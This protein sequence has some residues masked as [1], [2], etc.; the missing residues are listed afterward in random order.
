MNYKIYAVVISLIFS[1]IYLCAMEKDWYIVHKPKS[2]A[3]FVL[4]VFKN[5]YQ[6]SSENTD[7]ANINPVDLSSEYA[8][9]LK[10]DEEITKETDHNQNERINTLE[11]QYNKQ[12]DRIACLES[13]VQQLE[14]KNNEIQQLTCNIKKQITPVIQQGLATK[15][16]KTALWAYYCIECQFLLGGTFTVDGRAISKLPEEKLKEYEALRYRVGVK[17]FSELSGQWPEVPLLY[18]F[19]KLHGIPVKYTPRMLDTYGYNLQHEK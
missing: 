13:K 4:D 11:K 19:C 15:L 16:I 18:S 1:S 3:V 6:I 8:Q 2:N 10:Q 7:N 12:V 14:Q 9:A 17:D 5:S